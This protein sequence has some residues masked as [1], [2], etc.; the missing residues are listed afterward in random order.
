MDTILVG[1]PIL[2]AG[3]A[4][5]TGSGEWSALIF[6]IVVALGISFL[7]SVWEAVMLSVPVSHIELMVDQGS[8]AGIIMQGLRQPFERILFLGTF[9][10]KN[11]QR[12][13]LEIIARSLGRNQYSVIVDEY[14]SPGRVD[15][16]GFVLLSPEFW[17]R[18]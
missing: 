4:G 13:D 7:C 6:Y 18:R 15:G 11:L 1:I 5:A 9:K 14:F 17:K 16:L 3:T 8:R 2:A 10:W 12:G